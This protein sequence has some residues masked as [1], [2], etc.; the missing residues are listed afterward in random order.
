MP[1]IGDGK[2]FV[3]MIIIN[4][5]VD[6]FI[7]NIN[8][9]VSV[10]GGKNMHNNGVYLSKAGDALTIKRSILSFEDVANRILV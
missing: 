5:D 2:S 4:E 3:P 10:I 8:I 6:Y 1:W 9:L 7:T